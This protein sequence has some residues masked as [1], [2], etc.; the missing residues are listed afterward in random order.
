MG[1]E[2]LLHREFN[3]IAYDLQMDNPVKLLVKVDNFNGYI[4]WG[5]I[6]KLFDIN[7]LPS[8]VVVFDEFLAD[9][10]LVS[11]GK[12]NISIPDDLSVSVIHD[13]LPYNHRVPLTSAFGPK[14]IGDAIQFACRELIGRCNGKEF[15]KKE[16]TIAPNIVVKASSGIAKVP[17]LV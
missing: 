16:I 11:G 13:I 9:A 5:N 14:E 7:P 10:M 8:A 4:N 6:E 12:R 3:S 15:S 17:N 2:G 1:D